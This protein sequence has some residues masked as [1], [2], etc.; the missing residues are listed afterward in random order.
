MIPTF[1][2]STGS[3]AS[4]DTRKPVTSAKRARESTPFS[5]YAIHDSLAS[6]EKREHRAAAIERLRILPAWAAWRPRN[7]RAPG[8]RFGLQVLERGIQKH[9]SRVVLAKSGQKKVPLLR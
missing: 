5:A 7:R 2:N 8:H 6:A 3:R 4:I 9:A 1:L